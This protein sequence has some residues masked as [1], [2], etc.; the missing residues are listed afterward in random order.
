MRLKRGERNRSGRCNYKVVAL[1]TLLSPLGISAVH[2]QDAQDANKLEEIIV[3]AQRRA[4]SL[5]K[6]PVSVTAFS[7]KT[8]DELHIQSF[9]D[10]ATVV[11]GLS[12]TTVGNS[13]QQSNT[14]VAIRGIEWR[15][16]Q[17]VQRRL[18]G[19]ETRR[20][21]REGPMF[22]N[23]PDYV[24]MAGIIIKGAQEPKHQDANRYSQR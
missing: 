21:G 8:M 2:G 6:V 4:E 13:Q 15:G 1:S 9:D 16:K 23:V 24:E 17:I 11:P 19:L 18:I 7:Q 10:L 22:N 12:F 14:D 3:T 5:D 20:G